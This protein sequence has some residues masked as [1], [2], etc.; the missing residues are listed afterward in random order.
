MYSTIIHKLFLTCQETTLLLEVKNN[1][2]LSFIEN[3][4]LKIHLYICKNCETYQ[5]NIK[6]IDKILERNIISP[7]IEGNN[8]INCQQL[9]KRIMK[10]IANEKK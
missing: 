5:Q 9:K 4:R 3:I 6:I 2:P 1:L 10:N 7:S 8:N